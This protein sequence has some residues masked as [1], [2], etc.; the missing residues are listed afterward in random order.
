MSSNETTEFYITIPSWAS[1][2]YFTH[3]S[4]GNFRVQLPQPI[5]LKGAWS[6]GI[7]QIQYTK[8]WYN[9][10]HNKN[11]IFITQNKDSHRIFIT[12][13]YYVSEE[14]LIGEINK[15]IR[16]QTSIVHTILKYDL[17]SGK[18]T[19]DLP[20][21]AILYLGK[22][23]GGILG[24]DNTLV[25][26][27]NQVSS[28]PV[29][30]NYN[31][32]TIYIYCDLIEDQIVGEEKWKLINF[33]NVEKHPFGTSIHHTCVNP[34]Y[35]CLSKKNFETVHIQLCNQRKEVINFQKGVSIIQLHFKLT[36]I[37]L[38]Y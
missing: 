7:S 27:G 14:Q 5:D 21:E 36:R 38:F 25:L 30:L 35:I 18:C 4:I 23:L 6:V 8:T 12:E 31:C 15:N 1:K 22:Y 37:P 11:I 16:E 17:F 33:F 24:F 9:I 28:A 3:N 20:S 10:E 32:E 34:Q 19:I 13:G 2:S 29:N 26:T